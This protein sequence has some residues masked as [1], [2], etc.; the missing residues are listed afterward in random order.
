MTRRWSKADSNSGS[1]PRAGFSLGGTDG[2]NPSPSSGESANFRYLS[3]NASQAGTGGFHDQTS[4]GG[5]AKGSFAV[6]PLH[7]AVRELE[8]EAHRAAR[9]AA[10][11]RV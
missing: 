3:G 9:E 8:P 7:G 1:H 10:G 11:I 2:S 4:S 5:H 6:E